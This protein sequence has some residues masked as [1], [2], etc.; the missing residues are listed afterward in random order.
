MA[1]VV[2]PIARAPLLYGRR[3]RAVVLSVARARPTLE[4][5]PAVQPLRW[6]ARALTQ[7]THVAAA[8]DCRSGVQE[9]IESSIKLYKLLQSAE[10]RPQQSL[11]VGDKV[12]VS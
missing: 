8:T 10:G 7:Q 6:A 12:Q 1:A 11:L 9:G 2:L 4:P 3:R 5:K